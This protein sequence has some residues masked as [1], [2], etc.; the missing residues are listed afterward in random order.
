MG[1]QHF[2][3]VKVLVRTVNNYSMVSAV[4]ISVIPTLL[5]PLE[6]LNGT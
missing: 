2:E 1:K 4:F 6:I 3:F 5:N